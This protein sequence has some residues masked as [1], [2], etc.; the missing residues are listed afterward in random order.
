MYI[1]DNYFR[2][3]A[4]SYYEPNM[5]FIDT[6]VDKAVNEEKFLSK[7]NKHFIN[8]RI[9]SLYSL[10]EYAKYKLFNSFDTLYQKT[11]NNIC[12][13]NYMLFTNDFNF[14]L[15]KC[16]TT[17]KYTI[18]IVNLNQ[19]EVMTVINEANGVN[20]YAGI[21]NYTL[22]VGAETFDE[23][24]LL[25]TSKFKKQQVLMTSTGRD[26]VFTFDDF[27]T[28]IPMI[29]VPKN[30]S[31]IYITDGNGFNLL[32]NFTKSSSTNYDTYTFKNHCSNNNGIFSVKFKIKK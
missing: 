4:K 24:M 12:L 11:I 21:L 8:N 28:K 10:M 6:I 16:F 5:E 17:F 14:E 19:Y 15:M 7:T 26:V 13:P 18:N 32:P 20:I 30:L 22:N 23:S 1:Y 9:Y 31:M 3:L 2:E 27:T 29:V 25:N